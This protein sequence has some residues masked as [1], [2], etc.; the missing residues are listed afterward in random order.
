MFSLSVLTKICS[1]KNIE[2][3][4]ELTAFKQLYNIKEGSIVYIIP[5]S[6]CTGCISDIE[7]IAMNNTNSDSV[8][9]V[10]TRLN[11]LKLF[12]NRFGKSFIESKNII[13]DTSNFFH[14]KN[15]TLEIY[16]VMYKK[17]NGK[18]LFNTYLKPL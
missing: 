17:T 4:G 18:L 10:F 2:N 9:F 8:F 12:R 11:S 5:G 3:K 14:Y 6:G 1:C 16:P 13:L 15:E 7:K